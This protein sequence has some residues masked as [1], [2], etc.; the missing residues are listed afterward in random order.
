MNWKSRLF[1]ALLVLPGLVIPTT[2]ADAA[3]VHG[4]NSSQIRAVRSLGLKLLVPGYLPPGFR[5]V[6]FQTWADRRGSDNHKA[7]AYNMVYRGPGKQD[8]YLCGGEPCGG[9]SDN[10]RAPKHLELKH[11][12]FEYLTLYYWGPIKKGDEQIPVEYSTSHGMILKGGHNYSF[13][14]PSDETMKAMPESEVIR[15]L[16]HLVLL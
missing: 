2:Q 11:P 4:L 12:L 13:T 15:V 7:F 8:F 10:S 16:K 6:D 3:A 1:A 14:S 9:C 5:L